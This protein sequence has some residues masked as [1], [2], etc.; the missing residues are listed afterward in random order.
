[1]FTFLTP[2]VNA[3]V[4][5]KD[6]WNRSRIKKM[7]VIA[8]FFA[9]MS[10]GMA[11]FLF[12]VSG[13]L[14]LLGITAFKG[15]LYLCVPP[16]NQ[17]RK[18]NSACF[19][20]LFTHFMAAT[21]YG[22]LLSNVLDTTLL[23]IF[24]FGPA[25]LIL[26]KA[27]LRGLSL[28]IAF[29]I[30]TFLEINKL[31]QLFAPLTY[32]SP[33]VQLVVHYVVTA[34]ALSINILLVLYY[35]MDNDFLYSKLK[36]ASLFKSVFLRETSH[37]IRNPLNA[38]SGISQLLLKE[39]GI[40]VA[41]QPIQSLVK[42]QYAASY[43][44]TQI[45]DNILELSKIEE[46]KQDS[47]QK[48]IFN[49]KNSIESIM[50]VYQ[51]LADLKAVKLV[52]DYSSSAPLEITFDKIKLTQIINNLLIN[53]IKFT[54][55]NSTVTIMVQMKEKRLLVKVSD[56]GPGISQEN[57]NKIFQP[58]VTS[59]S[60]F[61]KSTGLGLTIVKRFTSLLEGDISVTS[62]EGAGSMFIVTFPLEAFRMEASF[63]QVNEE[64]VLWPI[65]QD[66]KVLI[67]E[68]D[69]MSQVVLRKV[70]TDQGFQVCFAENGHRGLELAYEFMPDIILLDLHMPGMT[71]K[72]I[73]TMLKASPSLHHIPVIAVSGDAFKESLEEILQAGASGYMVKPF[74]IDHIY[75]TLANSLSVSSS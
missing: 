53:A 40:N 68:D 41:Y 26:Q 39:I 6:E 34:S 7:N 48:E 23:C 54:T 74:Q 29:L 21:V 24:S 16:L 44:V 28:G 43:N 45:V 22:I 72:E 25:L 52:L 3:G 59:D 60:S 1:M 5:D 17:S 31:Y 2:M 11:I 56:H 63:I 13:Q 51:Y 46:G 9:G 50:L 12:A 55:D 27:W 4:V 20:L 36:S 15:C 32:P 42:Q 65:F 73:L 37:E 14:L 8:L 57:I 30:L 35:V 75:H 61:I 66:K 49:L 10:F 70:L 47:I 62:Q 18:H 38:I 64:E 19:L 58:F 67:L 71:G 33:M 69:R